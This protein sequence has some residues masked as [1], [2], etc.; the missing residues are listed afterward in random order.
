MSA[1]WRGEGVRGWERSKQDSRRG[2][3][4]LAAPRHTSTLCPAN[5]CRSSRTRIAL[6]AVIVVHGDYAKKCVTELV[7]QRADNTTR[8]GQWTWR[9][10]EERGWTWELTEAKWDLRLLYNSVPYKDD[11]KYQNDIQDASPILI[12]YFHLHRHHVKYQ[13]RRYLVAFQL[14]YSHLKP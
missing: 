1:I 5:W 12:R 11:S 13:L 9:G 4:A 10:S 8:C 2:L 7:A 3:G 6:K 14:Q